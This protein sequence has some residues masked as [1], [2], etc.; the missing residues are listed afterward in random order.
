M[1]K[2]QFDTLLSIAEF[3]SGD[4]DSKK[5]C[6]VMF[7]Q[8]LEDNKIKDLSA[9]DLYSLIVDKETIEV[10][11]DDKIETIKNFNDYKE[12][13]LNNGKENNNI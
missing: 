11:V 8:Y 2:E 7:K 3:N 6:T 10:F 5:I 9:I 12:K 1:L 4:E 13:I